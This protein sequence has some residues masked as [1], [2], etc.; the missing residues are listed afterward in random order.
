MY[1]DLKP[2]N[3]LLNDRGDCVLTDF[4]LSRFFENPED[5]S[6]TTAG[7]CEYIAPEII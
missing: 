1:R 7:T 6:M 5:V 3:I 4:G 2:E